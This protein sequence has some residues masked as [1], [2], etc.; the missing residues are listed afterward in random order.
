MTRQLLLGIQI[1][2]NVAAKVKSEAGHCP[3]IVHR[4]VYRNKVIPTTTQHLK[5][6]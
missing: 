6:W 3:E 2:H 5:L 4:E 1:Y